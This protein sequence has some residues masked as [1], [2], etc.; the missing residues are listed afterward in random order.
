MNFKIITPL[1]FLLVL[2]SHAQTK[3]VYTT[4]TT[5]ASISGQN[6]DQ[7]EF[8]GQDR[9]V[10]IKRSLAPSI[11]ILTGLNQSRIDNKDFLEFPL[12]F[13]YQFSPKLK[14]SGGS[15]LELVRNRDTGTF[16]VKGVSFSIGI[17]YQFTENWDAGIRFIQ[18]VIKREAFDRSSPFVP[19]PI[20]LR[21]GFKF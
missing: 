21:T 15:Q 2:Q 3:E 12:L 7:F 16:T 17:D 1:L 14:I 11:S 9:G 20:R 5:G 4:E 13:Q 6:E 10:F 8:Y 19:N 18:P